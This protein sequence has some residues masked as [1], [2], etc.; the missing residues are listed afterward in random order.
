MTFPKV[1]KE[2]FGLP[3]ELGACKNARV[4]A[5]AGCGFLASSG[6]RA[7]CRDLGRGRCAGCFRSSMDPIEAKEAGRPG[8]LCGKTQ[9]PLWN[10]LGSSR[11]WGRS[12]GGWR[13]EGIPRALAS[14][15]APTSWVLSRPELSR[16]E[17]SAGTLLGACRRCQHPVISLFLH[18]RQSPSKQVVHMLFETT[19]QRK[20]WILT[21]CTD[22]DLEA[23]SG[24]AW[25]GR[26]EPLVP[27]LLHKHPSVSRVERGCRVS[28]ESC[29]DSKGWTAASA[30]TEV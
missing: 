24:S 9:C 19:L 20:G 23:Q 21:H 30:M 16:P 3:W 26:G 22:A 13:Q 7:G 4:L 29:V 10:N 5:P 27:D 1:A 18:R 12:R 17:L 2:S 14:A 11:R 6:S 8:L 25:K 28:G 15:S